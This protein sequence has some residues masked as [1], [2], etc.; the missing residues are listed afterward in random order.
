MSTSPCPAIGSRM[1][2]G[3]HLTVGKGRD[4]ESPSSPPPPRCTYPKVFDRSMELT[5]HSLP[6]SLLLLMNLSFFPDHNKGRLTAG[7][8]K[9][10]VWSTNTHRARSRGRSSF[11][12][13]L[14]KDK[15]AH[16]VHTGSSNLTINYINGW[17]K[18]TNLLG[19]VQTRA[20][21]VP[22]PLDQVSPNLPFKT[23]GWL[24]HSKHFKH[25]LLSIHASISEPIGFFSFSCISFLIFFKK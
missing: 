11:L 10:T 4:A 25:H 9:P 22:N 6:S 17:Q 19:C 24:E 21:Q 15:E 20:P 2:L 8:E 18:A 5:L 1:K 14:F 3:V 12:L 16:S 23:V 7:M 13:C